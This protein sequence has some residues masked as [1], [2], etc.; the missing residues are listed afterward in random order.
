MKALRYALAN[1]DKVLDL[2]R[3][4]T[5]A[6]PDDPRPGYIFDEVTKYAAIDPAMPIP[7]EK[8]DWLQ[9]LLVK[10]GNLTTRST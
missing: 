5:D 3:Q 8:L 9:D 4:I 7:A 1:R 10:T 2:T 6:K